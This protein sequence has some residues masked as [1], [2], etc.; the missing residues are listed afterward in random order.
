MSLASLYLTALSPSGVVL[1]SYLVV[2]GMTPKYVGTFRAVGAVS[3]VVGIGL[4]SL[5]R[6]WG[7]KGKGEEEDDCSASQSARAAARSIERLRRVSL[8]FLLSEVASVAVAAIA[9]GRLQDDT[10][11]APAA[12]LPMVIFLSAVCASRAGL[13]SFDIG[14]LEI[15]QYVVDERH[16]NA[17]GSVEGALCSLVEMGMYLLTIALPNPSQFGWLVGVSTTAVSFS[18]ACF[19]AFLCLYHM[20]GHYHVSD[21][22]SDGSCHRHHSHSHDHSHTF[23]QE[24]DLEK[25]NGYHI[26]LHQHKNFRWSSAA[27]MASD[28]PDYLQ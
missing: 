26:H 15:E 13:Y 22:E 16:R 18:G 20:H 2:I 8:A 21:D 1:T 28:L 4:F 25:Y 12:S 24:R 23:Q 3:G 11:S 10:E 5:A 7:E 6:H 9:F 27:T 19:T 17:V 14:A